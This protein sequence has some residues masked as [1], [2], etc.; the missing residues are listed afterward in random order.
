MIPR[1]AAD[2]APITLLLIVH[3][4][5]RTLNEPATS[6]VATWKSVSP[7]REVVEGLELLGLKR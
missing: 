2:A 4:V 7:A 1:D 5:M 3:E 6:P